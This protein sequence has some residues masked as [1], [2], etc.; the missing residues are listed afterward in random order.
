[1]PLL[2]HTAHLSL[3]CCQLLNALPLGSC[4]RQLLPL[5]T[6]LLQVLL[7]IGYHEVLHGKRRRHIVDTQQYRQCLMKDSTTQ[8]YTQ[9]LV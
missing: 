1:M 9:G 4:C 8:I 5:L 3:L 6:L 7:V 2:V